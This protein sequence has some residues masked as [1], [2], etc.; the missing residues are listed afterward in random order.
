M[1]SIVIVYSSGMGHTRVIAEHVQLG[2]D[3]FPGAAADLMEILPEHIGSNGR[4]HDAGILER[5]AAADAIIFG[6]PTYMGSAHGLFKLFLDAGI[7]PW[8]S[9]SWKDK[10]GAGFTNSSSRSGDKLMAL[11]QMAIFAAQMSMIWVGVG[12][13]PGGNFGASRETDVNLSGSWLGLMSQSI[14]D[15]DE[16]SAPH[17]GDRFS[18]ERF[19]WRVARATTRWLMGAQAYPAQPIT[20]SESRRRN[21]AGPD[22]WRRFDG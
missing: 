12:D 4:W 22:E 21:I 10:I 20:E 5:I 15:G 1:S 14:S 18:A 2:V 16:E 7:T 8:L 9:Q 19:G 17:P 13:P 6:A 3:A 11:Q